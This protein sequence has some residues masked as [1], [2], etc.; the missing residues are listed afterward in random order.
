MAHG[1]IKGEDHAASN[2]NGVA[3]VE[4]RL[5]DGDLR[6]H[7]GAAQNGRQRPLRRVDRALDV[8]ELFFHEEAARR[9]AG[10]VLHDALGGRVRAVRRAKRVVD[11]R[12]RAGRR[13]ERGREVVVVLRLAL[14]EPDVL[15]Q[16]DAARRH[17]VAGLFH[18]VADAVVDFHDV[19]VQE[20]REPA[21]DR[22]DRELGVGL[23]LGPAD[24]RRDRDG[25]ALLLEEVHGGHDRA[26]P[27][28]VRDRHAVLLRQRHV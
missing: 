3:L 10:N 24:V 8:H 1:F 15:Q 2:K 19:R 20:L 21:D 22:R 26:E 5:D 25:R 28:V 11:V 13:R 6:R 27:R 14:V 12:R 16:H 17:G 9:G 4:H 23:A 7:L 18:V